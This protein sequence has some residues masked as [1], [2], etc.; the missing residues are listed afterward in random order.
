MVDVVYEPPEVDQMTDEEDIDDNIIGKGNIEADIA[1][2]FEIYPN[3]S[4]DSED[5]EDDNVPLSEVAKRQKRSKNTK[6]LCTKL[7][8]NSHTNLFCCYSAGK[9]RS[10]SGRCKSSPRK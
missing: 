5:S 4:V 2:T 8:K 9:Y 1:G 7:E 10:F 6:K 3:N